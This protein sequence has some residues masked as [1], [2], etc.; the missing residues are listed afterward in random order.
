[1]AIL[2]D[3]GVESVVLMT[4]NPAKVDALSA[5]G[6]TVEERIPMLVAANPFSQAYLEVKKRKMQHELP[7]GVFNQKPEPEPTEGSEGPDPAAA[8]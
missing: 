2:R 4:N 6:M 7:S 8:H 3:L 5:L 1:M